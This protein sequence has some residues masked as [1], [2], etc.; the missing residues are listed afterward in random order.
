MNPK[1]QNSKTRISEI[2]GPLSYAKS[3]GH[4]RVVVV[5]KALGQFRNERD[6]PTKTAC[7]KFM[8]RNLFFLKFSAKARQMSIWGGLKKS[9]TPLFVDTCIVYMHTQRN[10]V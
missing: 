1:F 3:M 2:S 7:D 6:S 5:F 10:G 9:T 4:T 8:A